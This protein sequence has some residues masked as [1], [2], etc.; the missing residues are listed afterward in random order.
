MHGTHE[1]AA[2]TPNLGAQAPKSCM[3]GMNPATTG[4]ERATTAENMSA[5]HIRRLLRG[6]PGPSAIGVRE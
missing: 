1:I 6:N 2:K 3:A 4:P 5:V